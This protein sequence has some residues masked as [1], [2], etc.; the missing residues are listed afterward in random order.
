MRVCEA[1]ALVTPEALAEVGVVDSAKKPVAVLARGEISKPLIVKA[2]RISAA[3]KQKIEA[4]GGQVELLP[5]TVDRKPRSYTV[6]T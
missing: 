1:N 2:H 4:A 6:I 5:F 3:A